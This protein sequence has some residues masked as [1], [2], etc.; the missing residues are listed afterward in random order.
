MRQRPDGGG[1]GAG[2]WNRVG[3][4]RWRCRWARPSLE[5]R[6]R[7]CGGGDLAVSGAARDEISW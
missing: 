7:P 1:G 4:G 3:R 2:G 5:L 6:R